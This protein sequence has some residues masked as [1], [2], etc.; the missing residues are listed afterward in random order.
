MYAG[1]LEWQRQTLVDFL[2][3]L[4]EAALL[5]I[6]LGAVQLVDSSYGD[7]AGHAQ[8]HLRVLRLLLVDDGV[9]RLHEEVGLL[10]KERHV[11]NIEVEAQLGLAGILGGE[12]VAIAVLFL[13][14]LLASVLN[15]LAIVVVGVVRLDGFRVGHVA[16]LAEIIDVSILVLLFFALVAAAT[17]SSAAIFAASLVASLV[18]SFLL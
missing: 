1:Q 6:A 5:A 7:V 16:D 12:D 4:G 2:H 8:L 3:A 10:F 18:A 9:N 13:V 15:L 11:G 14:V 17:L